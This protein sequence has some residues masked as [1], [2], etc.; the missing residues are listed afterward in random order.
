MA[1]LDASMAW[2]VLAPLQR[3]DKI[4]DLYDAC[5]YEEGIGMVATALRT[6][7]AC[8][9][10]YL[11]RNSVGKDGAAAL[12]NALKAGGNST[13]E[14]LYLGGNRLAV[15][16][17]QRIAH[18]LT[19]NQTL[20]VLDLSHNQLGDDGITAVASALPRN[21]TLATLSLASNGTT[22]RGA[23]NLN[24]S[25]VKN[26][27]LTSLSLAHS[28]FSSAA[29]EGFAD[30]LGENRSLRILSLAGAIIGDEGARAFASLVREHADPVATRALYEAAARAGDPGAALRLGLMLAD[31]RG[32]PAD[33][34]GAEGWWR[35]VARGYFGDLDK[36]SDEPPKTPA[37]R[38]AYASRCAADAAY[39]LSQQ[40]K[41]RDAD[42][43]ARWLAA[44]EEIQ[45]PRQYLEP[46][47]A[48]TEPSPLALE[49]LDVTSCGLRDEGARLLTEALLASAGSGG[50]GPNGITLRSLAFER[51]NG[52]FDPHRR[53]CLRAVL[54]GDEQ[55]AIPA[56]APPRPPD[57]AEAPAPAPHES[58]A[59]APDVPGVP[60][61]KEGAE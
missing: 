54:A 20:T 17:A 5:L 2:S 13:L 26:R 39:N 47:G 59:P 55:P 12:A 36:E 49:S 48:K 56:A 9:I 22:E 10:L 11:G 21:H 42:A 31:G 53:A 29:A 58:P 44:A 45:L 8:R 23:A 24:E 25:L 16:G 1:E 61:Q 43:A 57:V 19:F 38:R 18:M 28:K 46:K 7:T 41:H 35:R 50:P 14:A 40:L 37:T 52:P 32:G 30:M 4:V 60:E 51:G 15:E 3:P 33:A 6:N 34:A 27:G